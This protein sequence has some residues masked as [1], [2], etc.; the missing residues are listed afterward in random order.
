MGMPALEPLRLYY[1]DNSAA[2]PRNLIS[3]QGRV[4]PGPASTDE[5][6]SIALHVVP[7]R[8]TEVEV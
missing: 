4:K 8:E 5:M 1:Y 2:N 3:P 7:A 6:G